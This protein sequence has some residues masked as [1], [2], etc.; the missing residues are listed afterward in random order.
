MHRLLRRR[1]SPA[2]VISCLALFLAMGGVSY[3]VA[4]GSIDSREIKNNTV[5]SRDIR[6]RTIRNRDVRPNALDATRIR[7]STFS[8]V[9]SAASVDGNN[10]AKLN[11]RLPAG[12]AT[13]TVLSFGGLVLNATCNAAG[14]LTLSATTTSNNAMLHVAGINQGGDTGYAQDND[15]DVGQGVNALPPPGANGGDHNAQHTLTYTNP[16]GSVV[17]LTYLAEEATNGLGSANDCFA[18]GTGS[19]SP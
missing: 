17:N 16:E 12:S 6:N 13:R 11:V 2:L 8:T 14:D 1:P 3:G 18:T 5:R 10:F 7:E 19:Q 4:T 15:L 9:P